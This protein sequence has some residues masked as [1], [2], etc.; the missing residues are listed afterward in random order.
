[1]CGIAG[2]VRF[3]GRPVELTALERMRN[4]TRHRGPD[5]EDVWA[6]GPFGFAHN[7]LAIL[8]LS[9]AGHQPMVDLQTGNRIVY[10]GEVYNFREIRA[11][12][13]GAGFRFA[14]QCDT[15]VVLQAYRRWGPECL[16]RFNGMFAFA[17]FDAAKRQLFLARD[18]I[19]IKPLYYYADDVQFVFASETKALL[20]ADG[21][22]ARIDREA[23]PELLAFRYRVG[24]RT[25]FE[26]VR[27]LEPGHCI[28]VGTRE[29][30]VRRWW[31]VPLGMSPHAGTPDAIE[32]ALEEHLGRS[33]R[34]RLIA[35]VPVGCAL[36]GG[37]DSSLVT[38]LACEAST[39]TMRTFSIGFDAPESDE[40]P[41]AKRVSEALGVENYSQV[42]DEATFFER[43]PLLTWHMDEPI[44]HPNS[45]GIW[46]LA[47][48][49]RQ[50]VTVL[51]SG[52]G[53]DE[54]M[55]GYERFRTVL[56]LRALG[57]WLP[58]AAALA[59]WIRAG[60]NGRLTRVAR[61]LAR[62]DDGRII[63]SSAYTPSPL[64]RRLLGPDAVYRAEAPRRALLESLPTIDPIDRHLYYE[65]KTYLVSLLV[66][67]DK[68]CM[69]HGLENRVPIL[70]H[71][72]VEFAF[73]MP[74]P[75]KVDR[76]RGKKALYHLVERRFGTE[77]FRRRKMGFGLPLDYFRGAGLARLAELVTSR[78]FRERGLLDPRRV[79]ELVGR[80]NA[81]EPESV[82]AIWTLAMLELWARTFVDRGGRGAPQ[83]SRGGLRG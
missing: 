75:L 53:G 17:I 19:G 29:L 31:D 57:R 78:S 76:S 59:H 51:L 66:R 55:G 15:E 22:E 82:N 38:A 63:W 70:D 39:S 67:I 2:I 36:S 28:A 40:R 49:A 65:L 13:E 80:S 23:L 62:D 32:A 8:D 81:A 77:L 16:A 7:R 4:A 6:D 72:V 24:G 69:A 73:R 74:T 50:K 3:D 44:N 56:R 37:V 10:N 1:M 45:A 48:L 34:Y 52:E 11:D 20:L 54:L 71:R 41:F 12:L 79:D 14:S 64:L 25:M 5:D 21:V 46:L 58:G 47:G 33:V 30:R 27:E 61:E 9:P 35:D 43:L 68:M 42:L 83:K 18:R 26:G 60:P